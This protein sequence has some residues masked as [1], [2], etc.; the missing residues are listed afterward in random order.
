MNIFM[1]LEKINQKPKAYESY[2][3]PEL[4]CDPYI[5]KQ[6]LSY[7]LSEDTDLASRKE[8]LINRSVEWISSY[9]KIG[10]RFRMCDFGCG[11]GL[12][13]TRGD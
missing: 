11:P 10:K 2:T 8:S 7:H 13:T 9:F 1:M 3:T 12:Y 4:W 6:M 5:S